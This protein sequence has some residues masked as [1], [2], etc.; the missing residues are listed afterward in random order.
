MNSPTVFIVDDDTAVRESLCDLVQAI[1]LNVE[2]HAGAQ[3]FLDAYDPARPGCLVVDVRMPGMSGL[4]LQEQLAARGVRIPLIMITGHADVPMAV[5][6]MERGAF[7]F[8]EKPFRAQVLL[9][10]I[11]RAIQR[12]QQI[13]Q[14]ERRRAQIAGRMA[15]LTPRERAVLDR[16]LEGRANKVIAAQ[17]GI[18]KRTVEV[19]RAQVMHKLEVDSLAEL[20]Q[21]VLFF[22]GLPP[23]PPAR[24]SGFVRLG[25]NHNSGT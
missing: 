14:Q 24:P 25:E 13:R 2:T 9:D 5:R 21:Q 3:E 4:A 15:L 22:R 12:D 16:V 6:T 7:D 1:G 10:Q 23:V 11:Q 18:S 19:H 17:L 20:M 8:L